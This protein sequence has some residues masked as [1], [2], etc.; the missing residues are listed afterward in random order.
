MDAVSHLDA[1]EITG[2]FRH[3][4]P[5]HDMLAFREALLEFE[6]EGGIAGR[7]FRYSE[8]RDLISTVSFFQIRLPSSYKRTHH[9]LPSSYK[10]VKPSALA[11][12]KIK[13]HTNTLNSPL[14]EPQPTLRM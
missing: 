8:T 14:H 6:D 13:W 3:T 9:C 10:R 7:S 5:T 1:L 2:Q 4:F 11:N 12:S